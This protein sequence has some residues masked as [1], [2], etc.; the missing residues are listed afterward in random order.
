MQEF[1]IRPVAVNH[2]NDACFEN[3]LV[4]GSADCMYY[5]GLVN[6]RHRQILSIHVWCPYHILSQCVAI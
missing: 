1:A 6:D 4:M 2:E 5:A 3:G